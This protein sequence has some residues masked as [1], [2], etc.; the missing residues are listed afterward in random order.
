MT[1]K[2]DDKKKSIREHPVAKDVIYIDFRSEI[3]AFDKVL[4][5]SKEELDKRKNLLRERSKYVSRLFKEEPM[6]FPGNDDKNI[7]IVSKLDSKTV[8]T[9]ST[10]LGKKYIEIKIA[11]H[12][13]YKN[14]GVS[15]FIKTDIQG[16][17]SEANAGSGEFAVIQLVRQ[18][19]NAKKNSLVLL[20]EPEVSIHP[21][22]QQ[23][24]KE[25]L[26]CAI[27]EKKIQVIIST[28]SP[29]LIEGMP[30]EAIKLYRT[31]ESGKFQVTENVSY[32]EAFYDIEDRPENKIIIYCED[33][34]AQMIIQKV[35]NF[36]NKNDLFEVIYVPGGEKT[37][38]KHYMP[39]FALNKAFRDKVFLFLDGDMKTGY[40]FVGEENLTKKQLSDA[41]FLANEVH[42][43]FGTKIDVF[44]DGGKAGSRND[45]KCAIY[46]QYL[47]FYNSNV[48]F[49]GEEIIPEEI[50]LMSQ[51]VKRHYGA[52][53]NKYS[54]INGKNAKDTVTEISF[55]DHGDA[56]HIRDTIS[57]LANKWSQEVS[58]IK[59]RLIDD[60]E[61]I[62]TR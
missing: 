10:I 23:R 16:Q 46:L 44:S 4:H 34:T 50:L 2:Y 13:V 59:N 52:T 30:P 25:Y 61:L 12:K 42:K 36:M 31:T 29:T 5:F 18:I 26:L 51:Y 9:I 39:P 56:E 53:M 58:E 49:I 11:E 37:L 27:R 57:L 19:E 38:V 3:S 22:A 62:L 54:P 55:F 14:P 28:H 24:L 32:Q 33:Y 47:N 21:G 7:G 15:A 17:Y 20:D 6:R 48:F 40:K 45:Q 1:I 41:A 35:L 43:A 8:E 60:L